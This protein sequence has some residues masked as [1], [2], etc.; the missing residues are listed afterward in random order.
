[1]ARAA[2]RGMTP[3]YTTPRTANVSATPTEVGVANARMSVS[4]SGA[5]IIAPPPN[6]MMASPVAI[7]RRSGNQRISVDTGVMYPSPRPHPPS[8]PYPRYTSAM[9]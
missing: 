1:M 8:T 5:A 6:P 7:P 2:R 9:A 4:E 3:P